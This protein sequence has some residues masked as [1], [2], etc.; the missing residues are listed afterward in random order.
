[1]LNEGEPQVIGT[2]RH[3]TQGV[4]DLLNAEWNAGEKS[5]AG[6]SLIVGSDPYEIRVAAQTGRRGVEMHRGGGVEEDQEAGIKI[7][8]VEQDGWKLRVQIDARK[9]RE[10]QWELSFE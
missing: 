9:S 7:K 8:I 5:L 6:R 3:I 4:M 1:M 10:V 2:S